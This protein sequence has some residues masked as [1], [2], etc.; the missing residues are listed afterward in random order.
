MYTISGA[1][2]FVAPP[3]GN[4]SNYPPGQGPP[5]PFVAPGAPAPYPP[6]GQT[7]LGFEGN[8]KVIS[9]LLRRFMCSTTGSKSG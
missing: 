1:G 5:G 3:V 4:D 2:P 6:A 7:P 8:G 9:D